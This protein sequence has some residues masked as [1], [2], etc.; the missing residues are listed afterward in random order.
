MG[1]LA[2]TILR[3]N[4]TSILSWFS[5]MITIQLYIAS[6]PAYYFSP[7]DTPVCYLSGQV[8]FCRFP[9]TPFFLGYIYLYIYLLSLGKKIQI[10]ILNLRRW[11]FGG[12]TC[13]LTSPRK[14]R[15]K[16]KRDMLCLKDCQTERG[17][18]KTISRSNMLN[19]KTSFLLD[20]ERHNKQGDPSGSNG[21]R[22]EL[23]LRSNLDRPYPPTPFPIERNLLI[24]SAEKVS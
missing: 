19:P 16:R 11:G 12:R 23:D 3:M 9:E 21:L 6:Y 7:L 4:G 15:R 5:E 8:F 10:Q 2:T 13:W 18:E 14:C 17:R 1:T 20:R 22:R 24:R